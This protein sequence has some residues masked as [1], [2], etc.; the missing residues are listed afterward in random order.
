MIGSL[1]TYFLMR[2]G[3]DETAVTSPSTAAV[4]PSPDPLEPSPEPEET[5]AEALPEPVPSVE[6]EISPPPPPVAPEVEEAPEPTVEE[7][8]PADVEPPAPQEPDGWLNVDAYLVTVEDAMNFT[9]APAG[10]AEYTAERIS[11]V[12]SYG[13]HSDFWIWSVHP[14]GWAYGSEGATGADGCGGGAAYVWQNRN[15][16]W[17]D[18]VGMQDV[19]PCREFEDLGVPE[20]A[21]FLEC[22]DDGEIR[23]Y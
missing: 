20:N 23:Y 3:S 17:T 9:E 15:G 5:T 2:D 13:C 8:P 14:Q 16:T 12:D 4:E 6:Q 21:G 19:I 18:V 22:L 1:G 7:A 11:T 10:F